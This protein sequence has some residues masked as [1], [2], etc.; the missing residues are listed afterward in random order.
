[1]NAKNRAKGPLAASVLVAL[2]VVVARA[3][4]DDGNLTQRARIEQNKSAFELKLEQIEESA[5][6]RAA[7]ER[8]ESAAQG[9]AP[10]DLGSSGESLRLTPID[11][12]QYPPPSTLSESEGRLEAE[13]SYDR[14]Q[15]EILDQRQQ[16]RAL[17]SESPV[18]RSSPID[19]YARDRGEQVRF[20][21]ENRQ[22]TLQ[23]KLRP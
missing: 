17:R 7:A 9:P 6:Q 8:R 15:R 12:T 5:R 4:A 3:G 10:V 1:M 22:Q 13:Q 19:S 23:R 21:S 16:R 11:P 20:R 18:V 14:R 2:A